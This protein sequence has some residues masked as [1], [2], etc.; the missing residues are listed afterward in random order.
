MAADDDT[1]PELVPLDA[2]A[3]PMVIVL[4]ALIY[5]WMGWSRDA[6][7]WADIRPGLS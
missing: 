2:H 1:P 5:A 4:A 6:D 3:H 7:R